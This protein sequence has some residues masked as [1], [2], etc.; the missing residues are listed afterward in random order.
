MVQFDVRAIDGSLWV[1]QLRC[2]ACHFM[3]EVTLILKDDW[4]GKFRALITRWRKCKVFQQFGYNA[5][6]VIKADNDSVWDNDNAE[7]L[8]IRSEFEIEMIYPAK[9][10]CRD[11]A[12]AE[13]TCRIVEYGVKRGLCLSN[14]HPCY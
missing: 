7:W 4:Y 2:V 13:A 5:I 8:K 1:P 3:P 6:S 10:D 12:G 14:A 11:T 9:S